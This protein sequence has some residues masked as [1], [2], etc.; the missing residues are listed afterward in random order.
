MS[1]ALVE[2]AKKLAIDILTDERKR[3]KFIAC[4]AIFVAVFIL[5]LLLPIYLIMSPLTALANLTDE[6]TAMIA[7]LK[8]DSAYQSLG[9]EWI[10]IPIELGDITYIEGNIEVVYYN[11]GNPIYYSYGYG[12]DTIKGSACGP[13]SLAIVQ[14]TYFPD[15]KKNPVEMCNWSVSNGYWS[16]NSG[17]YHSIVEGY[18]TSFDVNVTSL[19]YDNPQSILDEL[20]KGNLIVVLMGKGHFTSNGHFMVLT[21]VDSSGKIII[22][23]PGS[24]KRTNQTW[25]LGLILNE[26]KKGAGGNGPIW[27]MEN[28]NPPVIEKPTSTT[29]PITDTQDY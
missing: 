24:N 25:D 28:P 14:S 23:D 2:I 6:E 17:S 21:G 11:Q 1:A 12:T 4:I 27:A 10:D 16:K 5:I 18:G 22:A 7:D 9:D 26:V 20:N 3:N 19:S 13:T 29:T 15:N 8:N